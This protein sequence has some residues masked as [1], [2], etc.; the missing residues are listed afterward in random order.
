MSETSYWDR[1]THAR[2]SRR[3]A[4][5]GAATVGVGAAA[6]GVVGCGGG[7]SSSSGGGGSANN[8]SSDW[9]HADTTAQAVAGGDYKAA[10]TSDPV[11]LDPN[12]STSFTAQTAG[13]I[14]YSR[15]LRFTTG[16]DIA[17]LSKTAGDAAETFEASDGGS[18]WTFHL[19]KGMKFHPKGPA[20]VSGRDLDADDVKA[21]YDYF[22]AK[23]GN[24]ATLTA[25]VDSFTTPDKST[26]VL[27]LKKAYAPFQELMASTALFYIMSKQGATGELDTTK[28]SGVVGTG[29][30]ILDKQT[31]SVS[32]DLK[33]HPSWYQTAK[34]S[35]GN[36]SLPLLNTYSYPIIPDY[37][38]QM[39]Q[40]VAGN[41][42][43]FAVRN[44][45]LQSVTQ[46]KADAQ[47]LGGNPG[48]LLSQYSFNMDNANNPMKD[49]R[50]R[51]ALSMSIDRDGLIATF[52][53]TAKL[54]SQGFDINTGWNNSPVP[55]GDGGLYWWLDPKS[56][57]QGASG[58]WFKFDVAQAKQLVSAA[59]YSGA[60]LD[61]NT[62]NTIYGTTFDQQTEAQL[63]MLKAIGLNLNVL[64]EDYTSKYFPQVYTK[65]NYQNIAYGYNTPFATIDEYMSRMLGKD[66][67]QN[68]SR[69]NDPNIEALINKQQVELDPAKRQAIIYD[70]QRASADQMYYVPSVVGRWGAFS[71]WSPQMRN[72]GSFITGAYGAPSESMIYYWKK[73]A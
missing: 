12:L 69:V 22:L 3:R 40:F 57:D 64:S 63:P 19:R 33:R 32:I 7:S 39:A 68:K 14:Y 15:L 9:A 35:T 48:W 72:F 28:D 52:G 51:R 11:N 43:V 16:P 2:L 21:S 29:P 49:V 38:Q 30:W 66:G 55:W 34:I 23:N 17:P 36:V 10:T 58:A 65:F 42:D 27:K 46:Q 53:E 6:L 13:D 45:D 24:R 18:T 37:A 71:L 41:L 60:S 56:K 50:L 26:I 5:A 44:A 54:K 61:F 4:L 8:S 20:S 73:T 47:K 67:D 70:I 25:L 31:P 59:G 62:T 1:L